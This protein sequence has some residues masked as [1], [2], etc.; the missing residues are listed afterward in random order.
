M[1]DSLLRRALRRATTALL[2]RSAPEPPA[3]AAPS[4][5]PPRAAP[6]PEPA[7]P[8]TPRRVN[9]TDEAVR[10][11]LSTVDDPEVGIDLVNLGLLRGW[12]LEGDTLRV[13]L[14]TTS[15]ACPVGPHLADSAQ[16]AVAAAFPGLTCIVT[17][18]GEPSWSPDEMTGRA[19]AWLGNPQPQ[20]EETIM[21]PILD[22][23]SIAP[24]D[25]H[26]LIFQTF[27]DLPAGNGFVLVNDHDPKPL[28]YQ[29]QAEYGPIFGWEYLERG[30]ETWKVRI[31]R[32]A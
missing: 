1:T 29:F 18:V 24:R 8:P 11:A 17:L 27:A 20:P 13:L 15:A 3:R 25:R 23:R 4:S 30:P 9:P 22:I 2:R 14:T 5:T 6:T 7:A 31:S 12:S 26:P 10:A 21:D 32:A 28:Y 19:Q 16:Q